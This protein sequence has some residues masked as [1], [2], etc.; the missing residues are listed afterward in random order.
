MYLWPYFDRP[1]V[2][3]HHDESHDEA[4][5]S[6]VWI[7]LPR[8]F[9]LGDRFFILVHEAKHAS[10]HCVGEWRLRV[11]LQRPRYR[12]ESTG[13]GINKPRTDPNSPSRRARAT[14]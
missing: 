8:L 4:P 13:I 10:C 5:V 11:K 14:L 2:L 12:A 7:Q 1:S 3:P 6:G 9:E